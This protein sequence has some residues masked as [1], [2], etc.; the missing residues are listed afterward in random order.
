MSFPP[1][2][3]EPFQPP[4]EGWP[5]PSPPQVWQ[6]PQQAGQPPGWQPQPYMQPGPPDIQPKSPGVAVVASLFLPGLGSMISGN[7]G[8][9]VLIL[10]LYVVSFLGWLILIGIPFTIGFWIWGMVQAHSDAVKWNRQHGIFS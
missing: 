7:V 8:M 6:P 4:P 5:P 2:P 10:C 1:P 3:G 9:G